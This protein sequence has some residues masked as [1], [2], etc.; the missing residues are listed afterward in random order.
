M[1]DGRTFLAIL[2]AP[3]SLAL[4]TLSAITNALPC[5]LMFA[6]LLADKGDLLEF[7]VLYQALW[8]EEFQGFT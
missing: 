5:R 3:I 2:F 7:P 8:V 6:R 4:P 1:E